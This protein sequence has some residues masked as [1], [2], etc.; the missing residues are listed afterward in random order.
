MTLTE[1]TFDGF[2]SLTV[3]R[4]SSVNYR[5]RNLTSNSFLRLSSSMG[6]ILDCRSIVFIPL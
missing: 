4:I 6:M 1:L 5:F 3:A 2:F